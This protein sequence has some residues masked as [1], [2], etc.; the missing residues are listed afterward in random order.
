MNTQKKKYVRLDLKIVRLDEEDV[1]TESI[2]KLEAGD[3][4]NWENSNENIWG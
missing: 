4:W 3:V 1:V 2:T